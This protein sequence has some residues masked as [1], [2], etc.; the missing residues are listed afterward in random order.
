MYAPLHCVFALRSQV[1]TVP[2]VCGTVSMVHK[3]ARQ[4]LVA[5]CPRQ[6]NLRAAQKCNLDAHAHFRARFLLA[7][8]KLAV[9]DV[10]VLCAAAHT[11]TQYAT[12][13]YSAIAIECAMVESS[14]PAI[15]VRC[16]CPI[17]HSACVLLPPPGRASEDER[18][19][20]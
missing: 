5:L 17:V 20:T 19:G 16:C 15:I 3:C 6:R 18:W 12:L 4:L 13:C 14:A 9:A 7:V 10:L 8:H 11:H 2:S 1:K